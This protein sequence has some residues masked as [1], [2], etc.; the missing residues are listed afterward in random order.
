MYMISRRL[1]LLLRMQDDNISIF[2]ITLVSHA[3][4]VKW[5]N[6]GLSIITFHYL[7]H[8]CDWKVDRYAKNSVFR[9]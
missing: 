1:V 8:L 9:I 6:C 3:C 5:R 2:Y 7:H 4:S